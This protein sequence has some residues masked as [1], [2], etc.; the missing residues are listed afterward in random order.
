MATSTFQKISDGISHQ[1]H[2]ASERIVDFKDD[3]ERTLGKRIDA[4]ARTVKRHPMS[5]IA[6][7]VGVGLATGYLLA[8]FIHRD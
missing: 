7:G 4:F 3:T 5:S 8:F 1:L 6:I 2:G